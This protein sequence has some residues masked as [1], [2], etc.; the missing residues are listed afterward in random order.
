MAYAEPAGQQHASY[1]ATVR[2]LEA[3][4]TLHPDDSSIETDLAL[5]F[6]LLGQ[7]ELFHAAISRALEIDPRS[8]QAYY[9][10]GRFALEANQNP[11]EASRAF[12][13]ALDLAPS[14]FKSH[15]YLGICLRQLA[16]LQA[17]RD[18]FQKASE[19]ATYSWPFNALAETELDLN[20]PQAALAPALKA[21]ELEPQSADNAL[22]AGRVYQASGQTEKAIELY[23][24]AAKLDPLWEMPHFRL[25]SVYAARPETQKQREKN[26]SSS[27][28]SEAKRRR[29]ERRPLRVPNCRGARLRRSPARSWMRSAPSR[30]P[31]SP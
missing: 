25:G 17:A 20:D 22:L 23:R 16:H 7:H 9:L 30:W 26:W 11:N 2:V 15:Y 24:Q 3:R 4:E 19:S 28:N 13:K 10:A 21:I 31:L 18:E 6:F 12:Q 8:A 1:F 29:R 27:K 14:S 5:N